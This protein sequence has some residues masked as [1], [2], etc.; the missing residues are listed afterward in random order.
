MHNPKPKITKLN[1]NKKHKLNVINQYMDLLI[2][3]QKSTKKIPEKNQWY[4][5][6]NLHYKIRVLSIEQSK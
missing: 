4:N 3:F 1:Y 5:K 6:S 2:N